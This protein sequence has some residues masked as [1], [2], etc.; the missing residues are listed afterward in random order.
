MYAESRGHHYYGNCVNLDLL[1]QRERHGFAIAGVVAAVL[2]VVAAGVGTYVSVQ[3]SQQAA[4]EAN[5]VRKQKELEAQQARESAAF[6]E[7]QQRRRA[8]LLLGKQQ[9]IE[10][11]AGVSTSS[12]SPFNAEIDLT[13]QAELE[14]LNIRRTGAVEAQGREWEA[15]IAKFRRDTARGAIPFEIA[16]GVLSAASSATS[17]YGSYKYRTTAGRM[18]QG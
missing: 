3:Q 5:M 1:E 13:T 4:E 14:A 9:A 18:Y 7:T 16:G 15:R 6:A 12:G 2:A 10:A 8:S 11:A 17:A